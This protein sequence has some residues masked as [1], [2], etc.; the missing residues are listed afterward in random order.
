MTSESHYADAWCLT[1]SLRETLLHTLETHL[2]KMLDTVMLLH[3]AH[4]SSLVSLPQMKKSVS[5]PVFQQQQQQQLRTEGHMRI[6]TSTC[7]STV[8]RWLYALQVKKD[9]TNLHRLPA[10]AINLSGFHERHRS[11]LLFTFSRAPNVIPDIKRT[12]RSSSMP[13]FSHCKDVNSSKT[14]SLRSMIDR[15]ADLLTDNTAI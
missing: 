9:I 11:L 8:A 5:C 1:F 15:K 10:C 2:L 3:P 14:S 7:S 6:N 13:T 12:L 4:H